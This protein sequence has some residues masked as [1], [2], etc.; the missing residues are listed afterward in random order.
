MKKDVPMYQVFV[1]DTS[2]H[3]EIP[4]G[5]QMDNQEALFGLAEQTNLAIMKKALTGWKDAHVVR[6]K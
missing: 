2:A 4:I 6:V 3:H 1:T 5:P